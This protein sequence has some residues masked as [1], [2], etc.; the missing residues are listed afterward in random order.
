[1]INEVHDSAINLVSQKLR[2]RPKKSAEEQNQIR[3]TIIHATKIVYGRHGYHGMSVEEVLM[4]AKL[5]R[6]TFYKYFKNTDEVIHII[7]REAHDNLIATFSKVAVIDGTF[8]DKINALIT[9]WFDWVESIDPMAL[10]HLTE[11][12]DPNSYASHYKNE[13]Q[14]TLTNFFNLYAP[15]FGMNPPSQLLIDL[16]FHSFEMLGCRYHANKNLENKKP[17]YDAALRLFIGL[18]G[19]ERE[20]LIATDLAQAFNL[21]LNHPTPSLQE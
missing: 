17:Y 15:L 3:Q 7:M 14:Q 12:N 18:F 5:S 10:V 11:M 2:G 8:I 6:P 1:M 4:V 9:G 19:Q 20:W 16:F 21:T 13:S